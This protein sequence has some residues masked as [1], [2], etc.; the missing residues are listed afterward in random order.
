M[1]LDVEQTNIGGFDG[2][3]PS[4]GGFTQTYTEVIE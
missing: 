1:I 3:L 4:G 2:T